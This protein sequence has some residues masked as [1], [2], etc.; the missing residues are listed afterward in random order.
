ME[1]LVRVEDR[2]CDIGERAHLGLGFRRMQ[3][4]FECAR[5]LGLR[6]RDAVDRMI[7]LA[8]LGMAKAP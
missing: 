3:V 5:I 1:E 8:A 6:E 7:G 2:E 4:R